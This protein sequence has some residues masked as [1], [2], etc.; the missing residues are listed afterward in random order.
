MEE[1]MI[2]HRDADPR[3]YPN[4]VATIDVIAN[5]NF[6]PKD[7]LEHAA[8]YF[9]DFKVPSGRAVVSL[10]RLVQG[11]PD[12]VVTVYRGAPSKGILNTGDWVSLSK[13]YAAQ[14][15]EKGP[16]AEVAKDGTKPKLYSYR[17]KAKEL[18]FSGDSLYECCY[19]GKK[20]G[21]NSDGR[22]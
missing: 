8:S 15:A 21:G 7:I 12:T 13:E 20:I 6:F 19:W 2:S 9:P 16:Y 1:Y 18:S 5:G 17:V 10:L 22:D 4:E 14:Y 3:E 11:A